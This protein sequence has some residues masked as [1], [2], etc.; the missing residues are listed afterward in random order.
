M[1]DDVKL[2]LTSDV[3]AVDL[4]LSTTLD[5]LIASLGTK[6]ITEIRTIDKLAQFQLQITAQLVP[7]ASANSAPAPIVPEPPQ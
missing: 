4:T 6:P 5:D 2:D 1:A 3:A 7:V